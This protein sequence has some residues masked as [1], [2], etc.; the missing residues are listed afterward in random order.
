MMIF[1]TAAS[2][3]RI[4]ARRRYSTVEVDARASRFP[5]AELFTS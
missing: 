3:R 4:A 1:E 5:F 2:V